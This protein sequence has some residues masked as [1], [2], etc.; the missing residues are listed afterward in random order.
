MKNDN[1][2]AKLEILKN[3]SSGVKGNN[4]SNYSPGKAPNSLEPATS[5]LF[6]TNMILSYLLFF[7][8]CK[9]CA[10]AR[11]VFPDPY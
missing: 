4:L 6:L 3:K 11:N 7:T 5:I 8:K 2:L 1:F 9:A 10:R